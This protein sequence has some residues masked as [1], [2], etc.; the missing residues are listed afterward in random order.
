MGEVLYTALSGA[1]ALRPHKSSSLMGRPMNILSSFSFSFSS[2]VFSFLFSFLK[3]EY[4]K[5]KNY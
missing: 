3:Y 1:E 5:I 2:F 4:F